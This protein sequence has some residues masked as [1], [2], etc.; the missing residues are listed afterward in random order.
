MLQ[1][2]RIA[3][4]VAAALAC[5]TALAAPTGTP[6]PAPSKPFSLDASDFK[7]TSGC[8]K[9][10]DYDP[11]WANHGDDYGLNQPEAKANKPK[12]DKNK[13]VEMNGG[14]IH[15]KDKTI[16]FYKQN[17]TLLLKG[18]INVDPHTATRRNSTPINCRA[19]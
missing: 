1:P 2:F 6:G 17:G 4:A 8:E 3:L 18:Q 14:K 9:L 13:G 19:W 12:S 11:Q 5:G 10:E 15:I 16:E 7:P